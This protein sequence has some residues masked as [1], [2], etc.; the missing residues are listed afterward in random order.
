MRKMTCAY[1][2]LTRFS[3]LKLDL[4]AISVVL[5]TNTT[6]SI[7]YINKFSCDV[8]FVPQ[9]DNILHLINVIVMVWVYTNIK[10]Y[11]SE[12][13]RSTSKACVQQ[14]IVLKIQEQ[15][16]RECLAINSH[17]ETTVLCP[18]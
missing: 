1:F 17:R 6:I 15:D 5:P 13:N 2:S 16:H 7:C 18:G 4:S 10:G 3:N 8:Q 12:M 11:V 9:C 14:M